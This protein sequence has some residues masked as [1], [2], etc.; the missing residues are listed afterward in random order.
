MQHDTRHQDALLVTPGLIPTGCTLHSLTLASSTLE[1][2][3]ENLRSPA[4]ADH[5]STHRETNAHLYL[6]PEDAVEGRA[7]RL[8]GR[9]KALSGPSF[10]FQHESD[11]D[12]A[13]QTV[14]T[15]TGVPRLNDASTIKA[16]RS[17]YRK[18]CDRLLGR[19]IPEFVETALAAI[20]TEQEA[21]AELREITRLKDMRFILQ[22]RQPRIAEDFVGRFRANTL[23]LETSTPDGEESHQLELIQQHVFED[24]LD[25]QMVA[26]RFDKAYQNELFALHQL[27]GQV[28]GVDLDDRT[29]PLS[30]LALCQCLQY[31][32]DRLRLGGDGRRLLYA[33]FEDALADLWPAAMT[34]LIG[35]LNRAGFRFLSLDQMPPNW[36]LRES[37]NEQKA[38][39]P[40]QAPEKAPSSPEQHARPANG[41]GSGSN[42]LELLE[43][44]HDPERPRGSAS[45]NPLAFQ[46]TIRA[47]RQQLTQRLMEPDSGLSN[48]LEEL[49]SDDPDL[50]GHLD[51][52]TRSKAR[53]VDTLFDPIRD[54]NE[55]AP[56]VREQ[57]TRLQ[58][59]IFESL[60]SSTDLL[61]DEQHPAR[62]MLNALSELCLTDRGTAKRL[63]STLVSI[64]E[65]LTDVSD[66]ESPT[67]QKAE[68]RLKGLVH[69]Q[70]QSFL[71]NSERLAQTLDGK[72]RL[73][74]TR[75]DVQRRLNETLGGGQV[76]E[77]LLNLLG[78]G[79]EQVMVLSAL[80]DGRDSQHFQAL[81]ET[82]E[83]LQDWLAPT[84][85]QS[86]DHT[87]AQ[88]LESGVMLRYI[89]REL[90]TGGM[91][92]GTQSILADLEKQLSGTEPV[93]LVRLDHYG[94][95]DTVP[96]DIMPQT[97]QDTRWAQRARGLKVGDWVEL[98][99]DGGEPRRMRLIWSNEDALRFVFLSPKG[100]T[101]T[102]YDLPEFAAKLAAGEAWLIDEQPP[103]YVEQR[104]FHIV[105]DV[106]KK[107]NAQVIHDA[108]TGC[109]HRHDFEK[110][111]Q[112]LLNAR[113][114]DASHALMIVDIDEFS[115]INASY[116]ASAGDKTLRRTGKY[117]I[118]RSRNT[119]G[120]SAV[121]RIGGNEFAL[122][123]EDLSLDAS[124]DLAESIRRDFEQFD[125]DHNDN[126][127]NATV[128]IAL[129]PIGGDN[130]DAGDLLNQG[131]LTVKSAKH[132]GG[133]RIEVVRHSTPAADKTMTRWVSEIDRSLQEGN[134][135]LRAQP[136]VPVYN[137]PAE[138]RKYELLL[139]LRDS[140]G[141]EISPQGY[142]EAAEQFHRSTKV[143]LWVVNEVLAW[144]RQNPDTLEGID[145][146]NVNL[147]GNS[148]SNDTFML[149]LE[150]SLKANPDLAGKLCF[151]VTETAAVA[152]LHF[153]ADFMR[154]LKR[155]NCRFAL[156]DFGTGLSSYA[157]LHKLPVDYIKIDGTFIRDIAS[158][159]TNYALVRSINELGHFLDIETIAEYVEDM[160]I[161]DTLREIQVD[162]A[163]GFGI[164]KPR[165]L[166]NLTPKPTTC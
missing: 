133:N 166:R 80:R 63:E 79:W 23:V 161:M 4:V 163:Q 74:K 28:F 158:N 153:A 1:C 56:S 152:N 71:R 5:L 46:K 95:S 27:L 128:S 149:G 31:T 162:Y 21:A 19:L 30:P 127:F 54:H 106:Y 51:H 165:P 126:R 26:R 160:E 101:E 105:E 36:S 102:G 142:I 87:V 47:R 10:R 157:Y 116:G 135:Y 118:E 111:L 134:L 48:V 41:I 32:I 49:V 58:V 42:V 55:L 151:E 145:T 20:E 122:L 140:N 112:L 50:K 6:F 143:D 8:R 81:L 14:T 86:G 115:V 75:Q 38:P 84:E 3:V 60:L 22:S 121:G 7:V 108:L 89:E 53:I 137:D 35:D 83:Q 25:L 9:I 97:A 159:L 104:L 69:Q 18:H 107:L 76:P 61:D 139:G 17:L 93:T 99:S 67:F 64:L 103:S 117:L 52:A 77:V 155:L 154:E 40:S 59:P 73:R 57:L 16:T 62:E 114:N 120:Q 144:M 82:V 33:A 98:T 148:L 39:P 92:T 100:M 2:V 109:L 124:L 130:L 68:S 37:R 70:N 88:D 110:R 138:G 125:F 29:N 113:N 132:P 150:S 156:D 65:D 85:T 147:S 34:S 91:T 24:W 13:E 141:V 72:E 96:L 44:T 66:P 164:A 78:S 94:G 123:L 45:V 129:L 15:G 12:I 90:A 11:T 146:L 136:I 119:S 43:M 131:S